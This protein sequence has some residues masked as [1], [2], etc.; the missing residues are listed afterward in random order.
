MAFDS[1]YC[2]LYSFALFLATFV[3]DISITKLISGYRNEIGYLATVVRV[4]VLKS[5]IA[6]RVWLLK[7][8]V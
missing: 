7:A 4:H 2:S 1:E 5:H 6:A 3:A 8:G